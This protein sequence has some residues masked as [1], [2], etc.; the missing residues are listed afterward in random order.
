MPRGSKTIQAWVELMSDDPEAVSALAVARARLPAARD[1]GQ[2]R[3]LRLI[4]VSGPLPGRRQLEE[5]LHRSIQFYNP[6]KERC[7]LRMGVADPVPLGGS[8]RVALVFERGGERRAAAERWW[9]HETGEEVEVR[10]GVAWA[11]R[12]ENGAALEDL[13]LVRGRHHGLLC[14]PHSQ[15][16]RLAVGEVPCPWMGAVSEPKRAARKRP[17][18]PKGDA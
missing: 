9:R 10:E 5:L 11:L 16:L 2:L 1:L 13:A 4:E 12:L 7:T 18:S 14:N 8:E 3:R 15:E 17:K 6:H